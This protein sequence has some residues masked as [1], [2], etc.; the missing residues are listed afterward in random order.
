MP[1]LTITDGFLWRHDSASPL[2]LIIKDIDGRTGYGQ[3]APLVGRTSTTLEACRQAL[4]ALLN[5]L[6]A[7]A[8]P[9]LAAGGSMPAEASMAWETAVADLQ[10]QARG[11]SLGR[12]LDEAASDAIEANGLVDRT[13]DPLDV[14]AEG[15]QCIKVKVGHQPSEELR[16]IAMVRNALG[17]DGTIRLDANQTFSPSE[18]LSFMQRAS[19]FD[20]SYIEEPTPDV[21]T[22]RG[23]FETTG[24]KIAADESI[25]S[26]TAAEEFLAGRQADILVL[27]PALWSSPRSVLDTVRDAKSEGYGVTITSALDG[28]LGT[29]LAGHIAAI[30]GPNPAGLGWGDV[31]ADELEWTSVA[32]GPRFELPIG[33]GVTRDLQLQY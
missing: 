27:K 10:A 29:L 16:R 2:V 31:R 4:L 17:S 7:W 22:W 15:Y 19:Q 24:M 13:T 18:A 21:T 14:V 30:A 20:I 25:A 3:A 11:M 32:P 33:L 28:V 23:L 26:R 6:P 5:R 12:Y 1:E 8:E 9:S